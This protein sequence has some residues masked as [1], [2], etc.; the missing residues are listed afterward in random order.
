MP[1]L[2]ALLVSLLYYLVKR[3]AWGESM[4]PHEGYHAYFRFVTGGRPLAYY[5]LEGG[6]A[7]NALA[8]LFLSTVYARGRKQGNEAYDAMLVL[9]GFCLFGV[10]LLLTDDA[11]VAA[12]CLAVYH[13]LNLAPLATL[14]FCNAET[15]VNFMTA[16]G[17]L[18]ALCGMQ[19]GLPALT[20]AGAFIA[21]LGFH[22]KACTFDHLWPLLCALALPVSAAHVWACLAGTA[23]GHALFGALVAL[24]TGRGIVTRLRD[25]TGYHLRNAAQRNANFSRR[26]I[27]RDFAFYLFEHLRVVLPFTPFLPLL[28]MRQDVPGHLPWLMLAFFIVSSLHMLIRGVYAIQYGVLTHFPLAFATAACLVPYGGDMARHPFATAA[29]I[30]I[31]LW[32]SVRGYRDNAQNHLG[33]WR[34]AT[35]FVRRFIV[36]Y[37]KPRLEPGDHIFQDG[38][39]TGLYVETGAPGPI[40]ELVWAVHARNNML[41]NEEHRRAFNTFFTRTRPRWLV[42]FANQLDLDALEKA[43]GLRY[44]LESAR[45]TRIYRL[46]ETLTPEAGEDFD[47]RTLYTGPGN[48]HAADIDAL[49]KRADFLTARAQQRMDEGKVAIAAEMLRDAWESAGHRPGAGLRYALALEATGDTTGAVRV[50]QDEELLHPGGTAREHL[51]RLAPQAAGGP[52]S[53]PVTARAGYWAHRA[54]HMADRYL[55]ESPDEAIAPTRR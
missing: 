36:D 22:A 17:T 53:G 29:I 8:N 38:H 23:A 13:L 12:V 15:V 3:S 35:F 46:V 39:F 28:F 42:L 51:A 40:P 7:P 9:T 32:F 54:A 11:R 50:L 31:G 47:P 44:R 27:A 14:S 33:E 4:Y 41:W 18:V 2:A 24:A 10:A 16:L 49:E 43:Y 1:Y 19:T 6:G 48:R 45:F 30:L 52:P 21:A 37:L 5:S 25:L 34:T 20:F 26:A 55:H